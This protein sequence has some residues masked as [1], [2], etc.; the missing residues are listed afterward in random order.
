M[1]PIALAQWAHD[2][3]NTLGTVAL[4]LESLERPAEPETTRIVTRSNTLLKKAASMCSDLMHEASRSD[5][6]AQRRRFDVM[7]TIGEVYDMIAPVVPEP[8]TLSIANRGPVYVMADPNDVFRILFN[9]T[10]NAVG[11]ARTAGTMRRLELSLEQR[12]ATV[13]IRIA[14]DGPG[15]PETVKARLFRR[16][17]ST[18]GGSGYGLSIAREL[19]ERNGAILELSDRARGTEFTLE[20]QGASPNVVRMPVAHAGW[21]MSW[22]A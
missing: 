12:G 9:L 11:V 22:V 10:H 13:T 5:M 15:L 1:Q 21:A 8:T 7:R 19:A 14:D 2:I 20:L 6:G 16:G 17:R 3:R 4:Y 18:T